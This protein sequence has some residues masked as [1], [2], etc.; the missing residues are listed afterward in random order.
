MPVPAAH[1]TPAPMS[2]GPPPCANRPSQPVAAMAA[3]ARQLHARPMCM[4][5]AP[6]RT[7][8]PRPPPSPRHP[9]SPHRAPHSP[10]G[11]PPLPAPLP[12]SRALPVPA[13]APAAAT[14]PTTTRTRAVRMPVCPVAETTPGA[15]TACVITR[16]AAAANARR[17]TPAAG[18]VRK[19]QYRAARRRAPPSSASTRWA[20]PT[21]TSPASATRAQA[22]SR[23]CARS[24]ARR[25]WRRTRANFARPSSAVYADARSSTTQSPAK[26]LVSRVHRRARIGDEPLRC[27]TGTS[28]ARSTSSSDLCAF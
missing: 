8:S 25:G 28:M 21:S 19:V 17:S 2:T 13:P 12:A 1:A 5:A 14:A 15:A 22:T 23:S 26:S 20:A 4:L 11:A 27:G 3:D 16:P 10:L 6:P 7:P 9:R 24:S 18:A